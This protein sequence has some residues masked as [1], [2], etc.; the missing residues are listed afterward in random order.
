MKTPLIPILLGLAC[1]MAGSLAQAEKADR[2]QKMIIEADQ[3]RSD[4]LNQ[5][6]VYS[7]NVVVSKGTLLMRGAKLEL[8]EDPQGNQF[9]TLTAQAGQR[10]F[11]RQKREG[12]NEF[13]EGEAQTI[14]YDGKTD[15]VKFMQNA[16][17]RRLQGATL[18]DQ[19]NGALIVYDNKTDVFTMTGQGAGKPG[20]QSGR[21][22]VMLTPK[23]SASAPVGTDPK[24]AL[25]AT[26]NLSGDK[27]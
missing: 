21:V 20:G 9:G 4:D 13:L 11:F 6:T 27:K 12:V 16:E 3:L 15:V 2:N 19:L 8:R 23:N 22:R 26:G 25:R 17:L 7:G 1:L 10:A 24:P 18:N 14:E 5:I